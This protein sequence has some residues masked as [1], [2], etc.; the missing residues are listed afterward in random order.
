ME[1]KNLHCWRITM[2][3]KVWKTEEIRNLLTSNDLAVCRGLVAIYN[4]QT[5]DEQAIGVTKHVNGVGFNGA[6]AYILTSYAHQVISFNP[7]TSTY[8]DPLSRKQI[9]LARKKLIKYARQLRDIAN[10]C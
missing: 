10:G 7:S 1:N 5:L 2:E 6:D 8:K 9:G 3:K 4:R